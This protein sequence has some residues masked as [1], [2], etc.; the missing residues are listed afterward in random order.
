M[1]YEP[2]EDSFLLAEQVKYHA[3]GTVLDMGTGTGI[4]AINAAQNSNVLSVL[5]VDK[6]L[7]AIQYCKKKFRHPKIHFAQSDLFGKIK[8]CFDTITFNPPYL[9]SDEAPS[10]DALIGGTKGWEIIEKFLAKASDHLNSKGIILLLFSSRTNKQKVEMLIAKHLLLFEQIAQQHIFFEDLY[11]YKLTKSK[12]VD[13]LNTAGVRAIC[14]FAKGKRSI[15]FKG[16]YKSKPVAIKTKNPASHAQ[17][18]LQKEAV[19]LEKLNLISI[20]PKLILAREH[21]LV[22][23][24]LSGTRI[25]EWLPSAQRQSILH[26]LKNVLHQCITLDQHKIT[27]EEMHRPYKHL[28]INQNKPVMIDFERSHYSEAPKNVTQFCQYIASIPAELQAKKI[29]IAPAAIRAAAKKYSQDG[30]E[31]KQILA[32][33]SDA[34][35]IPEESVC[36]VQ[37]NSARQSKF[38]QRDW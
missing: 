13:E 22:M 3:H 15:V 26:V 18:T 29:K 30:N 23:E 28:I 35:T 21:Y 2:Q 25:Q 24:F 33:F 7:K 14:H 16:I 38:I 12:L 37:A 9:P 8:K 31:Y 17:N 6:N 10:D 34:H 20:G 5:G 19:W 36:P 27:K 4:Q 32:L 1:L 11:V